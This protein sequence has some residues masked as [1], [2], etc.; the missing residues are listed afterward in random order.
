MKRKLLILCPHPEG[1][2][3][4]QRLK[5][6][7]FFSHWRS[8]GYEVTVS[9][10]MTKRF[11]DIVYKPGRLP[12]KLFWTLW[13]YARRIRDLARTPFYDGTYVFLWV[14]PFGP[15]LFER[16]VRMLSGRMIYDID[17]LVFLGKTS[18]ANRL[19][20]LLK[21][22]RKMHYLM[23]QADWVITCTPYLD[24]YVRKF[25][26]KTTDI[27]STINT[28]TYQPVGRYDND[29]VITLGWSGS[30]STSP[31]LLLLQDVLRE[32]R[33]VFEFRLLVIGDPNFCLGNMPCEA[34]PWS[35]QTEVSDLQRIDIGLYPLPDELWVQ[36]K[37][38][39][40]ALQYMAL[41]IP[42]VASAIG[43]NFRIIEDGKSGF[44]ARNP[45]EWRDSILA[46]AREPDLRRRIGLNARERVVRFYSVAANRAIYLDVLNSAYGTRAADCT[47]K[48]KIVR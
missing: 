10:F 38:G 41:G 46:L 16:A 42:T 7:Q 12:E 43:A 21:G 28:E 33:R 1:V 44:L 40:K 19:V 37:S 18:K 4:G 13:G 29:H 24:A 15:A 14:T 39:L 6:E 3:P 27:S 48:K 8:H 2:A 11:W 35:R 23:K 32:I 20:A 34:L 31:Y 26:P 36:G 25:N 45:D 30:H 9:P 5:Y 22:P 17:D 47:V